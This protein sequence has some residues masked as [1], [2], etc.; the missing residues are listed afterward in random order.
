MKILNSAYQLDMTLIASSGLVRL[1]V[2]RMKEVN[3]L[4]LKLIILQTTYLSD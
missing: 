1:L 3:F 4:S 2:E